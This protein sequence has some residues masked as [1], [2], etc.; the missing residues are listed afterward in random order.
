MI[1]ANARTPL[2]AGGLPLDLDAG[3]VEGD[4]RDAS[5]AE[6]TAAM[7][8]GAGMLAGL[9][10][11]EVRARGGVA[12]LG[13]RQGRGRLLGRRGGRAAGAAGASAIGALA[14]APTH[15]T[16]PAGAGS[17]TVSSAARRP[18]ATAR[19][20]AASVIARTTAARGAPAA[21]TAPMVSASMPPMAN[22]G[23]VAAP[24]A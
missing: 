5:S 17:G 6:M 12:R 3:R 7:T 20:S 22:H 18:A 8:S 19:G 16:L 13:A 1:S 10:R 9:Q 24:A 15:A 23:R 14:A 4:V 21:V 11:R 2:S